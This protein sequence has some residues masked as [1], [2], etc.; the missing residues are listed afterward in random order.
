[1]SIPN[2]DTAGGIMPLVIALVLVGSFTVAFT[3]PSLPKIAHCV[4]RIN[5][6]G[7]DGHACSYGLYT[8]VFGLGTYLRKKKG[9]GLYK[10]FR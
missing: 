10:L 4:T 9:R 2:H 5:N 1:M 3:V 6:G 7:N 8:A